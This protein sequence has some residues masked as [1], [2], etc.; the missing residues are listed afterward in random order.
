[1]VISGGLT[2][3]GAPKL[4]TMDHPLDP[5]NK[6]LKHASAESNEVI[7]FYSGNVVTDATGKATV[8]LPDYF[9]AIN[10]DPRYQLTV[11]GSFAQAIISKEVNNNTFEISTSQPNVKVSWE[12]KGVRNDARMRM[13]PFVSVEDKN[14]DKKGKYWDPV[15][16][17]KP[18]S[19][20]MGYDPGIESSLNDVKPA[21]KKAAPAT[22]GGSLDQGAIVAPSANKTVEKGGSLDQGPVV[23]PAAAKAAEKGGSTED[24]PAPKTDAKPAPATKGGSLDEMPKPAENKKASTDPGSTKTE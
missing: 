18:L 17:G 22:T 15:A 1:V 2:V 23:P 21:A 13:S 20:G 8:Q 3:L 11:I 9:G 10:I 5:A 19:M 4:F 6:T 12:V 7:N 14:A 24:V 16:Q